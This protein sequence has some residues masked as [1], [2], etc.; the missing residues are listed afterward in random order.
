MTEKLADYNV[1]QGL[2]EKKSKDKKEKVEKAK[3][4]KAKTKNKE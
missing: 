2:D 4:K 1:W 3:K